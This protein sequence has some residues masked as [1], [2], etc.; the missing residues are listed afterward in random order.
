MNNVRKL[1]LEN[2]VPGLQ[3][4]ESESPLFR[5]VGANGRPPES[6]L[7]QFNIRSLV[8][9]ENQIVPY[10]GDHI[11]EVYC[12]AEYPREAP[13]ILFR[14][15]VNI[16]APNI[17]VPF[18]CLNQWYPTLWLQD[19]VRKIA[20]ILAYQSFTMDPSQSLNK[21]AAIYARN[22]PE[23]FP[24]DKRPFVKRLDIEIL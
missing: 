2:E 6:Y 4:L 23:I 15:P 22:H 17:R 7:F 5:I 8:R 16:F 1:R 19:I 24:T 13:K 20:A 10:D 14:H 11:V 9:T 12:P 21:D 3:K 18:I